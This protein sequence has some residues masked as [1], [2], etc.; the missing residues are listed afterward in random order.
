MCSVIRLVLGKFH[1]TGTEP[2]KYR[3]PQFGGQ[4]HTFTSSVTRAS[5][6]P[7]IQNNHAKVGLMSLETYVTLDGRKRGPYINKDEEMSF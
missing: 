4:Y 6:R 1:C 2:V 5:E 3:C 7:T